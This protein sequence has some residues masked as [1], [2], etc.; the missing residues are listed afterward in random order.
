MP[1]SPQPAGPASLR[2]RDSSCTLRGSL[3]VM[4]ASIPCS[5][6]TISMAVISETRS[7]IPSVSEKPMAKSSTSC[8]VAIITANVALPY[9]KET[10]VS[11]AIARVPSVVVSCVISERCTC[12]M[13]S[14]AGMRHTIEKVG[15]IPQRRAERRRA[16]LRRFPPRIAAAIPSGHSTATPAPR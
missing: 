3:S 9:V 2:R 14:R 6:E 5:C 16:G 11:S 8:G 4:R 15:V 13:A 12:A 7:T 1:Q 10:A